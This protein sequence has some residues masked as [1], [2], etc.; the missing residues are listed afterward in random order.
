M[1]IDVRFKGS[2]E[3]P[4][5]IAGPTGPWSYPLVTFVT[6]Q[7]VPGSGRSG[8][9]GSSAVFDTDAPDEALAKMAEFISKARG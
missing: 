7:E 4:T 8:P 5:D 2:A 1:P 9:T 6:W 3:G